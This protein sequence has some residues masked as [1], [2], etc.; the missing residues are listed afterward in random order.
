MHVQ[1]DDAVGSAESKW[2]NRPAAAQGAEKGSD[3]GE[4]EWNDEE[5]PGRV[6]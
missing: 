1:W 6:A 4:G 5:A 2:R 3:I